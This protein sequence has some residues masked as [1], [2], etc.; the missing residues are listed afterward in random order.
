MAN[1]GRKENWNFGA[2][3]SSHLL[4]LEEETEAQRNS[5][6]YLRSHSRVSIEIQTFGL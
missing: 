6:T 4:L 3:N 1:V 2:G 5:E